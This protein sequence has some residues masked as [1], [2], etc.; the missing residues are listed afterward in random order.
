LVSIDSLDLSSGWSRVEN[1]FSIK[2]SMKRTDSVVAPTIFLL[3]FMLYLRTIAPGLLFGDSAEFQTIAYT[4]GMGHATGYPVYVIVAKFFTYLPVGEIAYR[5]NL[6]SAFFGAMALTF[7][8]LIARLIGTKPASAVFAP[9]TL[10]LTP[11]FWK[12][13]AIAEVYTLSSSCLAFIVFSLLMW[14]KSKKMVWLF[15]A[16]M[17]GGLSLG[18]HFTVILVAPAILL[19]L[20]TTPWSEGES[21]GKRAKPALFGV[22]AG[23]V[24]FLIFFYFLDQ[25]NSPAGI[26][27][28][29][30]MPS[31]SV[32][33]MS[34]LDFN[35]P[36][37]RLIFLFFS[38]QFRGQFFAVPFSVVLQRLGDFAR[39]YLVLLMFGFVGILSFFVPLPQTTAR[40]R[41]GWFLIMAL[42]TTIIFAMTY[43]V[44]DFNVFYIPSIL[45]LVICAAFG[46]Q[47]L[48]DLPSTFL[49]S[50][51]IIIVFVYVFCF[52]VGILHLAV[53]IPH[54]W[55]SRTPP[56]LEAKYLFGF[57]YPGGYRLNAQRIVNS[58]EDNAIVF[59]SWDRVYGLY[60]V[61]H[62]LQGRINQDFHETYPQKNVYLPAESLLAY[63]DENIDHRPIYFT[64]YPDVFVDTYRVIPTTAGNLF[65]VVRK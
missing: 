46:I 10:A 36:L 58:I 54:A 64:R 2:N 27:N 22:F 6:L 16:G 25:R 26:Y 20:V 50:Q 45:I 52:F 12:H 8:Y 56:G 7:L 65:Q 47:R 15:L 30:I 51:R 61:S 18:I 38:P 5:V 11:I 59:T 53:N 24:I 4:M 62:V 41:E 33:G 63:I 34:P 43:N 60:Y 42:F 17:F 39:S 9:L 31:L 48:V 29:V 55:Q 14:G 3:S 35:S 32:W 57:Q 1:N 37:K 40:S 49:R 28:T 23:V 13:A 21:L 44:A 19:Y